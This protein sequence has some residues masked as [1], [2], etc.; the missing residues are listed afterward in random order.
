MSVR[1][2]VAAVWLPL[3]VLAVPFLDFAGIGGGAYVKPLA[4]PVAA[5]G[6]IFQMMHPSG[7]VV[8]I[9]SFDRRWLAFFVWALIGCLIFP[10]L[11]DMPHEMKGQDLVVRIVRDMLALSAGLM[12]WLWLRLSIRNHLETIWVARWIV[13]SFLLVLPFLVVQIAIVISPSSVT[14]TMDA[15]LGL[16][17]SRASGVYY[18][19]IFG[20]APEASMLAD[21]L[22]TLWLPFALSSVILG[23]SIFRTRPLGCRVEVWLLV[24]SLIALIF[25]QSRIGLIALAFLFINGWLATFVARPGKVGFRALLLPFLML[26]TTAI[27]L[28][29]GSS[30]LELFMGSFGGVDSSIEGGVW[31][32]VTRLASMASGLNMVYEYPLGIGTGSFPFMFE[33]SVP[34]WGLAS[35]EIQGLIHGDTNYLQAVTGSEGGD[36]E[37]RLPD[38][39]ALPIRVLAEAGIPGFLMIFWIWVSLIKGCW[40]R[41]KACMPGDPLRIVSLALLL[42]LLTMLPLS[43]SVNSY[44]WVHWIL[45]A[46]LAAIL[47]LPRKQKL[48]AMGMQNL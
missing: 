16:I 46:A 35:P 5:L 10:W 27:L 13:R 23:G 1:P 12:F 38:A 22:L 19:K 42:S 47:Y 9:D 14:L 17:R 15:L 24:C 44:V 30:R 11:I 3:V 26:V 32:N 8:S 41:F 43:F 33:R 4:L 36:I 45:I 40:R 20:T 7:S 34:D 2:S 39:K 25:T 28:G 6:L 29:S 21:Q 48:L 18:S 31:S 37:I